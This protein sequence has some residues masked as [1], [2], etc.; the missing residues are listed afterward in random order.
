ME[1]EK[2]HRSDE[3]HERI[4]AIVGDAAEQIDFLDRLQRFCDHL[5]EALGLPCLVTGIGPFQWEEHYLHGPG[6]RRYHVALRQTQPSFKET[7]SL[8]GIGKDVGS[9]WMSHP[10][11]DLVAH[12]RRIPDHKE[13]YLGLSELKAADH[14]SGNYQ[15]LNDYAVWF[16]SNR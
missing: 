11:E 8:I 7:Y 4:I 6:E 2:A 1:P 9:E 10:L 12:V 16:A 13:F 15:L 3:Q 14:E 5:N